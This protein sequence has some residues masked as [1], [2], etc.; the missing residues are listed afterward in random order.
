MLEYEDPKAALVFCRT[1][2]EVEDLTDTLNAH[3]YSAQALHGGME[4]RVRDRV[5]NMFR[6]GQADLLIAT[7]VAARGIDIEHI[8]HVINYDV[9]SAP[10]V[11]IHRIGRTGRAGRE[12]VAIT[13]AEPREHRFLRNIQALT[14][15]KIEVRTVPTAADLQVRRLESTRE[16]LRKAIKAGG[17]ERMREFIDTLAELRARQG[18]RAG[19]LTEAKRAFALAPGD[20]Y[21]RDRVLA[22]GGTAEDANPAIQVHPNQK[23]RAAKLKH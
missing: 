3:G 22:F 14:K 18:D 4:Q 21:L 9:P 8:S 17:L 11:Y 2:L 15:Q 6:S 12:G 10:E 5:M 16:A 20:E 13:L 23:A 7:D 1:R 19:A